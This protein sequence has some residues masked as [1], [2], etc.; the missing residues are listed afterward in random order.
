MNKTVVTSNEAGKVVIAS[1]NNPEFGYIRVTQKREVFDE[2]TGFVSVKE[3]GALVLGTVVD[4][5][6]LGW[7]KGQFLD[8]KIIIK[9][10]LKPFN[11]KNA[12]RD[13]K[14]AG[15]TGIICC[16]DGQPIYARKVYT[17]NPKAEDVR[18]QHNNV[19]EIREAFSV[20][21]SQTASTG[22]NP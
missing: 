2:T 19:D 18:V 1:E 4:L 15:E 12:E 11:T 16:V 7:R 17:A 10:Q 8:G 14:V 6:S 13:Y 5:D 22:L 3:I 9:E 20:L 21:K